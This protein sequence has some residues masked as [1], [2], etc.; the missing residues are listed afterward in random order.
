MGK[1]RQYNVWVRVAG[2][3]A[4]VLLMATA[5]SLSADKTQWTSSEPLGYGRPYTVAADTRGAGN[6]SGDAAA[7]LDLGG[8]EWSTLWVSDDPA[9]FGRF[10]R[11]VEFGGE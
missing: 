7:L 4:V 10:R 9:E 5:C 3:C 8:G 1:D 6:W 2:W 11:R